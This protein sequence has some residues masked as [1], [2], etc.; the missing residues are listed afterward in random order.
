MWLS[1]NTCCCCR[2]QFWPGGLGWNDPQGCQPSSAAI[3]ALIPHSQ[4]P[5]PGCSRARGHRE[6]PGQ[7][8]CSGVSSITKSTAGAGWLVWERVQRADRGE[9]A[10]MSV[11]PLQQAWVWRGHGETHLCDFGVEGGAKPGKQEGGSPS[12]RWGLQG[13][14]SSTLYPL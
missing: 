6:P 8:P 10:G 9:G 12:T 14:N 2:G 4:A 13:K 11:C 1:S 3:Q 5:L 7:I